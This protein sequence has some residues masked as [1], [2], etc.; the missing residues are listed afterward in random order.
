MKVL[1]A[2]DSDRVCLAENKLRFAVIHWGAR[3]HYAVPSVL[4]SSGMLQALYT[5]ACAT[6]L[7]RS[8]FRWWPPALRPAALRR[9]TARQLPPN[10]PPAVVQAYIYPTLQ[11]YVFDRLAGRSRKSVALTHRLKIG[12]HALARQAIKQGFRGANAL[13]VHPCVSTDAVIEAKRRGL[14]VV[15]EAISHP[16]NKLVEAE[17]YK[18]HGEPLPYGEA[19]IS[20][21]IALFKEEAMEA[22]LMLAASPFVRD[23][24]IELGIAPSAISTVPYGLE[25]NFF[26]EKSKPQQGRVL[27]VGNVGYLKGVH[28]LAE[29]ARLLS[30]RGFR[31]EVRVVGSYD[32][33][34]IGKS[35]FAGPTYAGAMARD[36][37]KKE[38]LTADVFV[39]PTLS[40]GFGIVLLEAMAAGLPVISTGNCG[41]VVRNGENGF[42]VSTRNG[43]EIADRIEQITADRNLRERLS[44][45]AI[46]TAATFSLT[47]YKERLVSAIRHAAS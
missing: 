6:A 41:A 35:E 1:D 7:E 16:Y 37:V 31:G 11:Q 19:E 47:Q 45:G 3:L 27:Y 17:E 36:E 32:R 39:F 30:H 20:G 4:H 46:A 10:L 13:Y 42:V 9:F 15:L 29:A 8:V 28:Y 38:F 33:R 21:N 24:L 22:D 40:D 18:R 5:D 25:R 34:L 43:R 26:E 12:G 14:F 44:R 2:I 23:G